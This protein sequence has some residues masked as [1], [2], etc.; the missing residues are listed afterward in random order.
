MCSMFEVQNLYNFLNAGIILLAFVAFIDV[1]IRFKRPLI[2]KFFLLLMVTSIGLNAFGQLFSYFNY[3]SRAL[4]EIPIQIL[5]LTSINFVYQLYRL[6]FSS[7]VFLSCLIILVIMITLPMYFHS[8]YMLD[9]FN[10]NFFTNPNTRNSS[11]II[12]S[13][14]HI[15]IIGL[16]IFIIYK[17]LNKYHQHNIY[18]IELRKWCIMLMFMLVGSVILGIFKI[19]FPAI[20]I[21]KFAT[22]LV[23]FLS[24]LIIIIYRPSFL[25][26]MPMSISFLNIFTNQRLEPISIE[27][28]TDLF[29]TNVY[30]LKEKCNAVDFAEQMEIS[31]DQLQEFVRTDYGFS[32]TDLVNKYRILYF[33]ELSSLPESRLLTIEALSRQCGFSSRQNMSKFFKKFH[34]GNP[35][36]LLNIYHED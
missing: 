16:C 17:I 34:G 14:V 21:L 11:I 1:L 26:K 18:Y 5:A 33:V 29:F 13:I 15:Y 2:L 28:F 10:T 7:F 32:F 22:V 35:S 24:P 27:K 20:T 8:K 19:N 36:D 6:K 9:Y 30:Y 3:Y 23:T 4:T 25:N 12:R 31:Q